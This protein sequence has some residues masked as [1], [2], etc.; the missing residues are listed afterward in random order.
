MHQEFLKGPGDSKLLPGLP[1][2][3]LESEDAI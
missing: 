3:A 1:T 2:T